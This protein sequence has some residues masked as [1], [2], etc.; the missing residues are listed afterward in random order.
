MA[1]ADTATDKA[2]PAIAINLIILPSLNRPIPPILSQ[3]G[4]G[5][6]LVF[7]QRRSSLRDGRLRDLTIFDHEAVAGVV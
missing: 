5:P 6:V 2:K 1:C 3:Q 4:N 7:K